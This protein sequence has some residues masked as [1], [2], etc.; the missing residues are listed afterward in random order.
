MKIKNGRCSAPFPRHSG[1]KTTY[2]YYV[3]DE[4][5]KR[6]KRSTGAHS[7]AAAMAVIQDRIRTGTL[8]SDRLIAEAGSSSTLFRDYARDFF[9]K[10]KCPICQDKILR[11]KPYTTRVIKENRQRLAD[12]IMPFFERMSVSGINAGDIKRWQLWLH[13]KGLA[14]STVNRCRSTLSP[15]LD[16]AVENGL[17]SANPLKATKPLYV[18][19]ESPREAFT[20]EEIVALFSVEWDSEIARLA[21]MVAAFTG[22]RI[23]EVRAL[24]TEYI[25]DNAIIIKHNAEK[26]GSIK[27]TKSE[28][29]RLCPIPEKLASELIEFVGNRSGFIFTLNGVKPVYDSYINKYL[30]RAMEK[31]GITRENLSFHSTRHFLNSELVEANVSGDMI[32]AVI[33]HESAAMTARYLHLQASR[34]EPVRETQKEI[35]EAIGGLI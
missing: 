35:E 34:M 14:N 9:I 32:R 12:H 7:K 24:R 26:D 29:E 13:E 25:H 11:G 6:V 21:V 4:H 33:G 28:K 10:D 16:N 19:P 17:L 1:K 23:G 30:H 5:G 20:R 18:S 27:T 15:I 8:I 22:M 3:Y 2:Y 31:A